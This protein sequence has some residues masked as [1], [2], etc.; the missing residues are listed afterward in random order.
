MITIGLIQS[1]SFKFTVEDNIFEIIFILS[2]TSLLT[3]IF[4]LKFDIYNE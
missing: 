3:C 4:Y 2:L 1:H